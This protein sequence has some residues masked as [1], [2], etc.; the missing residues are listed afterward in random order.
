MI[1]KDIRKTLA[2][3]NRNDILIWRWNNPNLSELEKKTSVLSIAQGWGGNKTHT[4]S[5]NKVR[6]PNY[7]YIDGIN[8]LEYWIVQKSRHKITRDSQDWYWS[9]NKIWKE[10][11]TECTWTI[12]P[13]SMTNAMD[14]KKGKDNHKKIR[15]QHTRDGKNSTLNIGGL[16]SLTL[17][18]HTQSSLC[19]YFGMSQA[20]IT[21][22]I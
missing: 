1:N 5:N 3:K 8:N 19:T 14:F 6:Y 9:I 15:T 20:Y 22:T 13:T 4:H 7:N 17:S 21:K 18:S 11:L 12:H 16:K 10:I 2:P